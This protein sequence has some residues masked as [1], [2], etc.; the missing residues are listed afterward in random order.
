MASLKQHIELFDT[1]WQQLAQ[2][3]QATRTQWRDATQEDF[4]Q[5]HWLPLEQQ[6]RLTRR[7]LEHLL[8]VIER[9]RQNLH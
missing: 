2:H 7:E 9:A 6:V 1:A 5:Q 3:W 8:A 4:A